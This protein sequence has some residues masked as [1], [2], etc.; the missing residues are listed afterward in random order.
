MLSLSHSLVFFNYLILN[1]NF[2]KNHSISFFNNLRRIFWLQQNQ[3]SLQIV[4]KKFEGLMLLIE[5]IDFNFLVE[6]F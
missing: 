2:L 3:F 1:N 6:N 4:E 5:I